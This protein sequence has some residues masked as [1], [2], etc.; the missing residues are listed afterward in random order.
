VPLRT[1]RCTQPPEPEGPS[2]APHHAPADHGCGRSRS[3]AHKL[4]ISHGS[5]LF[6]LC[7]ISI[8]FIIPASRASFYF[9]LHCWPFLCPVRVIA[10][11]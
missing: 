8:T 9:A 6:I 10:H 11:V 4:V 2:A 5:N 1:G 3:A 7:I